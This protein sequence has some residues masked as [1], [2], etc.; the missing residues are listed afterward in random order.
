MFKVGPDILHSCA[1]P[2]DVPMLACTYVV[3]GF[4]HGSDSELLGVGF[5]V[6]WGS[7]CSDICCMVERGPWLMRVHQGGCP[8]VCFSVA[9]LVKCTVPFCRCSATAFY[10]SLNEFG[11]L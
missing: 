2:A 1:C 4:D 9:Q 8:C 6:L 10:G 5:V 7:C 11:D 3:G